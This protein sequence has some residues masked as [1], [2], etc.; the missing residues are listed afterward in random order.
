MILEHFDKSCGVNSTLP[1][2]FFICTERSVE[3]HVTFH[4]SLLHAS[5]GLLWAV[6]RRPRSLIVMV[7]PPL[8]FIL[9]IFDV[10][11]GYVS[12]QFN[13]RIC[14][15]AALEQTCLQAFITLHVG[16]ISIVSRAE[17]LSMQFQEPF[18]FCSVQVWWMQVRSNLLLKKSHV[19]IS[20]LFF[21]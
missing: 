10:S 16:Y 3:R 2:I 17:F 6:L 7:R 20:R 4:L 14:P 1:S 21:D 12:S 18:K 11:S 9:S 19:R 8:L 15:K 5:T 13:W